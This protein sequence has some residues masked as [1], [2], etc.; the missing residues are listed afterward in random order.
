MTDVERTV[1]E[2]NVGFD[3]D[4]SDGEGRI[5]GKVTPIIVVG[6]DWF[7]YLSAR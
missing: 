2:P 5:E 7:L 3:T 1:V 6:V 4:A